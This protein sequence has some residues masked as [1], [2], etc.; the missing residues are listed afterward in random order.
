MDRSIRRWSKRRSRSTG[1]PLGDELVGQAPGVEV[2]Q[3]AGVHA[4]RPGQVG[5]GVAPLQHGHVDAGLGEVAGEQQAG[6]PGADDRDGGRAS[7]AWSYVLSGVRDRL[8]WAGSAGPPPRWA[9]RRPRPATGTSA[10][11][12]AIAS[13]AVPSR[14][15]A[16]STP[17]R[18]GSQA[19]SDRADAAD[20]ADH[21][22]PGGAA[23]A[24]SSWQPPSALSRT[25]GPIR[26]HRA[27][28]IARASGRR[29]AAPA[30][31]S[32]RAG[33]YQSRPTVSG[34][35]GPARSA[36]SAQAARARTD[37]SG[38]RC[39]RAA[40]QAT[41][42]PGRRSAGPAATGASLAPV[43]SG[44]PAAERSPGRARRRRR[45]SRR[46]P[47]SRSPAD[48]AASRGSSGHRRER[49]GAA[50][51]GRRAPGSRPGRSAAG[52][53][54]A[55][56][57]AANRGAKVGAAP[58]V[59]SRSI[60]SVIWFMCCRAMPWLVARRWMRCSSRPASSWT[61][62]V[63]RAS[64]VGDHAVGGGGGGV[65]VRVCLTQ[66]RSP[67]VRE[68]ARQQLG[69]AEHQRAQPL[70]VEHQAVAVALDLVV[71]AAEPG[72][73]VAGLLLVGDQRLGRVDR[74]ARRAPPSAAGSAI[75]CTRGPSARS[76]STRAASVVRRQ[77]AGP[78]TGRGW[79][80]G[81]RSRR[82]AGRRAA[83]PAGAS[84]TCAT[85]AP[86]GPSGSRVTVGP[87]SPR[88]RQPSTRFSSAQPRP[89]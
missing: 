2:L 10:N 15:S 60:R 82:T 74:A 33:R 51:A 64:V 59:A 35:A 72:E 16:T 85:R 12:P 83:R 31:T 13:G 62:A 67:S 56:S 8:L 17:V 47:P 32:S 48:G 24:I 70:P 22:Q 44:M 55:G 6:G 88:R 26:G 11:Q 63:V 57:R 77:P 20:G 71:A 21:H 27:R 65:H 5:L 4:E 25:R 41:A 68:D 46:R 54:P 87:Q 28:P 78:R 39:R 73:A 80:A 53:R 81:R 50:S 19:A 66:N 86:A 40:T 61:R 3:R 52:A 23:A 34:T 7:S 76:R 89:T 18:A 37:R 45:G 38:R 36:P 75:Q 43:H 30:A 79:C 84:A 49:S 9:A 42:E 29:S 1:A 58:V 14:T 69:D